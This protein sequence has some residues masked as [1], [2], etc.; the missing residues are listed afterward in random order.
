MS[1]GSASGYDGLQKDYTAC[2]SDPGKIGNEQIVKACSRL[3][4]NAKKENST[5]GMFYALRA[6]ANN[7]KASNCRDAQKARQLIIDPN[8]TGALDGL[9]KAN[10][11]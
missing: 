11:C 7:D 3:I 9:E 6:A 4:K 5:I 2:M 8:L 1:A 10:S